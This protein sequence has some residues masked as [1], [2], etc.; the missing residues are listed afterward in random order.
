MLNSIELKNWKTHKDTVLRFSKGTNILV[1]QMGAGKSSVMDAISYALF[2]KYPA[3]Q[4]RRVA[5]T[6]IITNRPQQMQE[7][8]VRLDF[9]IG[10]DTYT[11]T[12]SISINGDTSATLEKNGTY[13]QSQPQR[14]NEEIEKLLKVDYDLF[15]RAVYA[16]QNRLTYFLEL[17]PS[18]RKKEIDELLGLNLFANAQENATTLMNK[19]A[20]L[21]DEA[22]KAAKGFDI[23]KQKQQLEELKSSKSGQE[24]EKAKSQNDLKEAEALVE[25]L[26]KELESA[27]KQLSRKQQLIKEIAELKSRISILQSEI[28]KISA[29]TKASASEI[30]E[31]LERQERILEQLDKEQ[32]E[33]K[34]KERKLTSLLAEKNAEI[35]QL[36][37]DSNELNKISK[38]MAGRTSKELLARVEEAKRKLAK[39]Q[40]EKAFYASSKT[41]NEK[42]L[43]ELSKASTVNCPVCDRPL[44]EALK[45]K[46]KNE[47]NEL[48]KH[49]IEKMKSSEQEIE[50]IQSGINSDE[51]LANELIRYEKR[52]EEL[53]GVSEKLELA[54]KELEKIQ[55][56]QQAAARLA[57]EKSEALT[58]ASK[59]L[60]KLS[61][62]KKDIDRKADYEKSLELAKKESSEKEN[63]AASISID[64][65]SVDMLH[66][67]Y[68]EASSKLSSAKSSLQAIERL[69]QETE[70]QISDK[71]QE[72]ERI[73]KL[74]DDAKKKQ[75]IAAELAKYKNALADTQA[76]LR[77]RLVDYINKTMQMI[78]PELYPYS[79]Y[80]SIK[81]EPTGDDYVLML[82]TNRLGSE[83]EAVEAIASGGERSTACLAMRV[84]FALVLVP[85][86]KWLILDEPTHNIDRQ[87]IELF[88]KAVSEA[89]PK[90]I[91][92][93]FIITHD[94][95]LKQAQNAKIYVFARDKSSNQPTQVEQAY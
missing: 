72:I 81:I 13:V 61:S 44:D 55:K 78:W 25:K 66:K 16:E 73:N 46:L 4:H 22:S 15:T 52:L 42:W 27:Q 57:D 26:G 40:E 83:W 14:V 88:V 48:I 56:E 86:L 36:E 62:I 35:S 1:G 89:L 11:V 50:K 93:I 91:E 29:Q 37:K 49:A 8:T 10:G 65:A 69:L 54:K 82:R 85:N 7:A 5:V 63:E 43:E 53:V 74:Y 47:K 9:E 71:Q 20:D 39:A 76:E 33:A 23:E 38:E 70:R 12:R 60:E 87:G 64:Q 21:A 28:D 95:L 34:E 68:T 59:E 92:Q 90:Y 31:Q 80:T 51:A 18:E 84:A 45:E 24:A 6:D 41:E 75:K 30:E 32:K 58:Q 77:T 17:S 3:L 79:D 94:E 67:Q 2:G 19:I